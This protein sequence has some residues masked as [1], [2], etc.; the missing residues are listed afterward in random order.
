MLEGFD[1]TTRLLERG[2]QRVAACAG[3]YNRFLNVQV[4]ILITGQLILCAICA[5]IAYWWRKNHGFQRYFLGLNV[6]D[7][8]RDL[9]HPAP[10]RK[11]ANVAGSH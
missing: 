3:S 6:Y 9:L 8:A 5:A 4:A 2:G 11:L 10:F 1:C 7:Q